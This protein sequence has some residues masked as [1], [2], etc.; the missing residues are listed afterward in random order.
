MGSDAALTASLNVDSPFGEPVPEVHLPAS[1]LIA[2]VAQVRFPQIASITRE[3]FIGPFQERIRNAFPVLRQEREVQLRLTPNGVQQTGDAPVWRFLDHESSPQW[4]VSL[5]SSFV[6]LDTPAYLSHSDFLSRLRDVL[7]ALSDTIAPELCD[8]AGIRYVDRVVLDDPST[9]LASLVR[10]E[11]LGVGALETFGDA[12]LEHNLAD[13]EFRLT[14]GTLHGRWGRLPAH[15][16]LDPLHGEAISSPCWIL[17]LDMYDVS[18]GDFVPEE[19]ISRLSGYAERIYRFFRWA[20]R[21][22][23]LRKYGGAI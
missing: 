18:V 6:A 8:R 14:D 4:K 2:V 23:L 1:P 3:D 12:E 7:V 5:A 10:T 9:D 22:D 15:A 13:V 20:V 11:V 21:L 19:L 16:Q 17:D